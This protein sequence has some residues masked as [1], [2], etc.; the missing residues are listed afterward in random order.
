MKIFVVN[1]RTDS[2]DVYTFAFA[3]KPT[4]ESIAN[5]I[6]DLE[7]EIE[8]LEWYIETTQIEITEM[9]LMN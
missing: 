2:G 4:L 9:E 6:R 3:S 1:A 7:G 5:K 8:E